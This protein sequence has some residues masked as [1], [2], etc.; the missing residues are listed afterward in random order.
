[1]TKDL[2]K[3]PAA[4]PALILIFLGIF[5]AMVWPF[6]LSLLIGVILAM[7]TRPL[8]DRLTKTGAGPKLAAFVSLLIMFAVIIVPLALFTYAAISQGVELTQVL[9]GPQGG[10]LLRKAIDFVMALKPAAFFLDNPA[11]LQSKGM[12]FLRNAATGLS[13]AILIQAAALPG[14][15]LKAALVVLTWFFALCQGEHF[16]KWMTDRLPLD[17]DLRG[18]LWSSFRGT[19]STIV[20]ATSASATAQALT[21]LAGFWLLDIPGMFIAAGITFIFGW[22]P[23]LGS[24]P[25]CLAGAVYLYMKGYIGKIV[26]LA[27]VSFAA[28]MLDYTIKPAFLK[29]QANM[30]P[31]LAIVSIFAG[32]GTFGILG[33]I[34]GP[35]VAAIL[36]SLLETWKAE[37]A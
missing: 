13:T 19:T 17:I 12:E 1:M 36:F 25:V 22:I 11:A 31:L 4:L 29:G 9:A 8:Y 28:S 16:M 15:T 14:V 33:V 5:M 34:L 32:I 2:K 26:V 24:F 23:V 37:S 6:L 3:Y 10:A 20:W 30:H 21:V 18:R 27:F 35:V 7:L